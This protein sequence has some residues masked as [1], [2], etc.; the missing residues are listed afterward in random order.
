MV[1][2]YIFFKNTLLH[3][4]NYRLFNPSNLFRWQIFY[5]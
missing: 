1:K 4:K 5:S 3:K 2:L